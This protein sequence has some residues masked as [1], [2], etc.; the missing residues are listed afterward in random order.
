MPVGQVE[1]T[2]EYN[3]VAYEV[4]A[5]EGGRVLAVNVYGV[6]FW[7]CPLTKVIV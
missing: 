5:H 4:L 2:F 3:G 7:F 1:R 6:E